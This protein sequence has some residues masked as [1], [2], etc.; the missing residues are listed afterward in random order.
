MI[1]KINSEQNLVACKPE[2]DFSFQQLFEH[3]NKL[4]S[5]P[6]F[7]LG[8]NGLYD[9][10]LVKHV[11]GD[12]Q[13]LLNTAE[14]MEDPNVISKPA[15]IAIIVESLDCHMFKVFEGY[16]LMA[17]SSLATYKVFTKDTY[18]QALSFVDLDQLPKFK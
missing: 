2:H 12:L 11:S 8:M 6:E 10:T 7:K 14:T 9:F 15:N 18:S 16:C 17:S 3:L 5:D 1:Y 13:A 4:L